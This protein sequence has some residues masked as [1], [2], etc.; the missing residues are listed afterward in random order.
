MASSGSGP[1]EADDRALLARVASGDR[2]ALE[3]LYGRHAGW[4]TVRLQRRCHDPEL[5]DSALQDT[6][7]AVWSGAARQF[8]GDGDVAAW[9][10]GIGVRKLIDHLRK[11]R[12]VPVDPASLPATVVGAGGGDRTPVVDS[13]ESAALARTVGAGD[14]GDAFRYLAPELQTVL[15]ATAVDGLTTREAADLLGIPQ[16]TVKTRLLRARTQLQERLA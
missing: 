13:A 4:L 3:A 12:P 1:G 6:F 10:W 8:R 16:G 9:L 5:V 15:L 14:L 7:V 2:R 11:R